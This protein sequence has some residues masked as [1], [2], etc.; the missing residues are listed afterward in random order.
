MNNGSINLNE[1]CFAV[2][3]GEDENGEP[4]YSD[5]LKLRNDEEDH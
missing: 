2:I 4:I 5:F 3:E 1:L